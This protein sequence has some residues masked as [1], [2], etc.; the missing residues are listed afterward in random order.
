M[1]K[2]RIF[3]LLAVLGIL[4]IPFARVS[5]AATSGDLIAVINGIRAINGLDPVEPDPILMAVAQNH[6]NYIASIQSGSHFDA[7]GGQ[8]R[9]RAEDRAEGAAEPGQPGHGSMIS[10]ARLGVGMFA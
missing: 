3:L 7:N 10:N 5:S 8:E 9:D 6:A 1:N 2:I 4:A